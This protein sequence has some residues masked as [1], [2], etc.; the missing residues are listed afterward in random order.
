MVSQQEATMHGNAQ[1]PVPSLS[2]DTRDMSG[3]AAPSSGQPAS[4]ASSRGAP[5]LAQATLR[6]GNLRV[7]VQSV[8]PHEHL[9][10][11]HTV[12]LSGSCGIITTAGIIIIMTDGQTTRF[13]AGR[14][15]NGSG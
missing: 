9:I 5:Y 11:H 10:I 8:S 6:G 3:P 4:Y 14:T 2:R 7:A 15:P 12:W 13:V 1:A